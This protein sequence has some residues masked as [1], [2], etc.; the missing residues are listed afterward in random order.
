M[1][2]FD[3]RKIV[4]KYENPFD[5]ILL[6]LCTFVNRKIGKSSFI[7]PNKITTFSLV[8]GI[9]SAWFI[10]KSQFVL[11]LILMIISYFGDCLDGN[12][13]RMYNMTSKF[14]DYYDH[15]SDFI[16]MFLLLAAII[17]NK[18]ITKNSKIAFFLV[19]SVISILMGLHL[20]CQESISGNKGGFLQI[21]K[22]IN[23]N[24]RYIK[25]TRFFGCGT[26]YL[27]ISAFLIYWEISKK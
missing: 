20:N 12:Y 17:L 19:I 22:I 15:L 4:N 16:K 23:I 10:Y 3:G 11:G 6:D 7:T 8:S 13:A 26:L 18:D 1:K 5:N 2:I 9:L 25:F 24:S 27:V 21:T 14:G